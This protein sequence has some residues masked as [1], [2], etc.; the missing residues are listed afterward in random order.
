MQ[1]KMKAAPRQFTAPIYPFL[2]AAYPILAMLAFN[3]GELRPVSAVRALLVSLASGACDT[4]R[5]ITP[6]STHGPGRPRY[7]C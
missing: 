1:P 2:L 4:R 7:R 5:A 6:Y 3:V